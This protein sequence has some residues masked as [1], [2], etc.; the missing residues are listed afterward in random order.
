M[1]EEGPEQASIYVL[2]PS[3]T[4]DDDSKG[5]RFSSAATK[6]PKIDLRGQLRYGSP[7]RCGGADAPGIRELECCRGL[8]ARD[9]ERAQPSVV[10]GVGEEAFQWATGVS[11][12]FRWEG[13]RFPVKFGE[14]V[15]WFVP[16]YEDDYYRRKRPENALFFKKIVGDL[17]AEMRRGLPQ[18][19]FV[20]R[21]FDEGITI[22]R[23]YGTEDAA[24]I[25]SVLERL[26]RHPH[27]GLDL[28]TDGLR[29]YDSQHG[30]LTAAV[31]TFDD[32]VAFPLNWPGADGWDTPTLRRRVKDAFGDF[33]LT[34]GRKIAHNLKFEQ[35]WLA[36]YFGEKILRHTEWE[37]TMAQAHT[38]HEVTKTHNLDVL[39]RYR[40]GFFLKEKSRVDA[41][42]IMQFPLN[43]VLVYNGMDAKWICPL[44][45]V[46]RSELEEDR[47]QWEYERKIRLTPT[48]SLTQLA[49]VGVDMPF[50]EAKAEELKGEIHRQER[51]IQ[52]TAEVRQYTA[53]F[54]PF[55]PSNPEHVVK[56]LRFIC[57]REECSVNGGWSSD[58]S[59][60]TAV[61]PYVPSAKHIL[62]HRT[63]SKLFSTYVLPVLDHKIVAPD[64]LIHTEYNSMV[65]ET[66]RLSSEDPNL[67]NFPKR[68]HKEVR[69]IIVPENRSQLLVAVDYGQIEARV[70]AM[71]SECPVLHKAMWTGYDIH[72]EWCKHLIGLDKGWLDY[73]AE[74]F[75]TDR[76][77]E[78][79]LIKLGRQELKNKWVF[80]QFFGSTFKACSDNLHITRDV[81]ER[82]EK[83][84][85]S[86]FAAVKTW[87]KK[88]ISGYER[89]LYVETL[90][91]RRRRGALSMNQIINTPIQGT[92]S[93]I[94]VESMSE[95]SEAA[96]VRELPHWQPRMNVHDDLT[97]M[98]PEDSLVEDVEGVATIMT[99]VRFPFIT[100][101]LLVEVSVGERWSDLQ[102]VVKY[103]SEHLHGH[104]P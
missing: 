104:R 84:F 72:L 1:Q 48:L 19:T 101:P 87:Q 71:A 30:I 41:S 27:V 35:T 74:E 55:S 103:S 42:R 73:L 88:L 36:Y 52:R 97:F 63:A 18:P 37:D 16:V 7:V 57:K 85:W 95:V 44:Y 34:S 28:E 40:F 26:S 67:Q 80:P 100:V 51:I 9:I 12:V 59:V 8:V 98:F 22:P 46:Q 11:G 13:R 75:E 89:K 50:A 62:E 102:E 79:S 39:T 29:P 58:E 43:E 96:E 70:I 78:A 20:Q 60:L 21:G 17:S 65:A 45:D 47:L 31:G 66:G 68:K 86:Q 53:Q 32:V 6:L 38:L 81:G 25:E 99:R 64:G 93:D 49:G 69:G 14:H 33:L 24:L 90:T 56:L 83:A 54:G 15:C 82:M 91:G 2:G 61:A 4:L 77:D 10:I 94:V 5:Q 76:G 3:P 92:A 23:A